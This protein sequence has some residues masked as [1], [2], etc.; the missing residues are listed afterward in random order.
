[1]TRWFVNTAHFFE[2][3]QWWR[4]PERDEGR[5]WPGKL[6]H[7]EKAYVK[8]LLIKI[9]EKFEYM[10]ELRD[11]LVKHPL[12]VLMIGFHPEWDESQ[13]Y[14]FAVEKTVPTARWLRYKQ[15][16]IDNKMLQNLMQGTVKEL[17]GEIP[18]M[19]ETAALDTKHI[20]A[21]VRENNLREMVANRYDPEKQP[22]GD[23]DCK[24]G[25]KRRHNQETATGEAK[26]E[27]EYLWGYG[28]GVVTATDP[29]Y[30]DVVLAEYTLPFNEA[31]ITYYPPLFER[32]TQNLSFVP[33]NFTADAAFDAWYVY[34]P[35]AERSGMVAIPLNLRGFPE[36]K[37]GPNGFHLCPRGSEMIPSYVYYD[38]H[39]RHR[40]QI[41]RCPLLHP[42]P[43][44][45]SC[46]HAQFVKGIGC[47]KRINHELG[48]R[49]RVTL[50]RRSD[51]Y[52]A[53]YK[54][55][56]SAE[57]IN[58]QAKALGIERPKVRNIRSVCNLNTLIYIVINVHALQRVKQVNQRLC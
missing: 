53:V 25:V 17:Q 30:G 34:Q 58:S 32:M 5:V 49:L 51:E 55:R 28:T 24:L 56:T 14:G 47:E 20:Y 23:R 27:K 11:F 33:K 13:P 40:V 46:H 48:G 9:N 18:K 4:V 43:T 37:L 39:R 57:R 52:K 35:F 19:A 54:Q 16:R 10:T 50:D 12:L 6:P 22:R 38:S 26:E 2:R 7:P 29:L 1:V 3:L 41:L 8:A 31:D 42:H 44:G 21:W 15:E 45:K 36:P